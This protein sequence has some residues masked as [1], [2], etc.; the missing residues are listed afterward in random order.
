MVVT[1]GRCFR[2]R[3]G[4]LLL[5]AL[6]AA[7]CGRRDVRFDVDNARAHVNMLAG[8]IGSRPVGSEANAK[9]RSYLIDQ[10][11]LYGFDVRVQETDAV[12][13]EFYATTHV[14]NVIAFKAGQQRE[15]IGIVAHYDSR[16]EAPGATDD[17]LGTAVAL[18]AGRVLASKPTRKYSLLVLLT[19]GEE[20]GMFGAAAAVTDPE[21]RERLRVFLNVESIGSAGPV[22]LFESGP[23][24][25]PLLKA[26]VSGAPQPHGASYAAEIY[27]RLPNDTDFTMLRAAGM[28]GLNFA[29]VGDSYSYHTS[30]DTPERLRNEALRQAGETVVGTVEALEA[31]TTELPPRGS[32]DD[33]ARFFD[34]GQQSAFVV[35]PLSSRALTI[36]AVL[37]ALIA[38]WRLIRGLFQSGALRVIVSFFWMALAIAASVGA[39]LGAAW[40]LRHGREVFHPWYA[41]PDRLLLLLVMSGIAGWWYITRLMFLLP[42]GGRSL[43][44]PA[45]VWVVA[46]P[47]WM[48]IAAYIEYAAPAASLMW[49]VPLLIA[50]IALAIVPSRVQMLVRF[51]S[52]LIAAVV[53]MIWLR[54]SHDLFVFVVSIFGRLPIVTP[55][56]VYP[57]FVIGTAIVIAPP[58]LAMLTGMIR[59]RFL[60]SV[61]SGAL[62]VLLATAT[63]L[64]YFA[65]AYTPSRPLRRIARYTA[66]TAAAADAAGAAAEKHAWWEV[67]GN[68]PGLDLNVTPPEAP[69]WRPQPP[70]AAPPTKTI[71]IPALWQAPFVFRSDADPIDPPADIGMSAITQGDTTEL[72]VTVVPKMESMTAVFVLPEGLEPTQANLAGGTLPLREVLAT[73][74]SPRHWRA[75]FAAIPPTGIAFRATVPATVAPRLSETTVILTANGLGPNQPHVPTWLPT[76]R[77]AWT[78]VAQ[79]IVR[80]PLTTKTEPVPRS[81]TSPTAPPLLGVPL[82]SPTLPPPTSTP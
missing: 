64:A 78:V 8:T 73:E 44:A 9:A 41:H 62:L 28:S 32:S 66:D 33:R 68:E 37:I 27:K 49:S 47:I 30:R 14:A 69:R 45:A 4:V 81:L 17:G 53:C 36:A 63:G 12:R 38:W 42:E 71:S 46:L 76:E 57:A 6:V 60:N 80:P 72:D 26:W 43:R 51:A 19:D 67:G 55:F 65:D 39:M 22:V 3:F 16:P 54:D 59:G 75:R 31:D 56:W 70:K 18:E 77:A 10:L 5:A 7:A 24:A 1:L 52:L 61:A 15:A 48:A 23:T 50:G 40:L 74:D 13:P 25:L 34:I 82:P 21:V 2:F 35:G 58:F 79:W 20:A 11:K 29:A